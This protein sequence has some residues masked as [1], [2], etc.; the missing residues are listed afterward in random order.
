MVSGHRILA[1]S[2]EGWDTKGDDEGTRP[3]SYPKFTTRASN[4]APAGALHLKRLLAI[5]MCTYVVIERE[6][7]VKA[8]NSEGLFPAVGSKGTGTIKHFTFYFVRCTTTTL[9]AFIK[10]FSLSIFSKYN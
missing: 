2:W 10:S 5:F 4:V 8:Q 3:E 1:M 7:D 9:V 6:R